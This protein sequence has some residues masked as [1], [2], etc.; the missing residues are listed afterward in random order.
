MAGKDSHCVTSTLSL[1]GSAVSACGSDPRP[2]RDVADQVRPSLDCMRSSEFRKRRYQ[3]SLRQAGQ[4]NEVRNEV[5]L[6]G[7]LGQ[8][9][10][11]QE[12]LIRHAAEVAVQR[13]RTHRRDW[14]GKSLTAMADTLR[15]CR[16]LFGTKRHQRATPGSTSSIAI[17]SSRSNVM[18]SVPKSMASVAAS[19]IRS[20]KDAIEPPVRW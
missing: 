2:L 7:E 11:S 8:P 4:L 12:I 14:H 20:L 9:A 13:L 16:W 10:G 18:A 17:E 19:I 6:S 3:P 15:D 1:R 5:G